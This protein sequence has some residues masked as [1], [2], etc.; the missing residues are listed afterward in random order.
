MK[1]SVDHIF[2][3]KL[4]NSSHASSVPLDLNTAG[5]HVKVWTKPYNSEVWITLQWIK[6]SNVGHAT[7]SKS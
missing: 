3:S 4:P 1:K 5:L 2:R 6:S 7:G